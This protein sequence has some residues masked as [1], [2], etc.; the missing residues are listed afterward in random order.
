MTRATENAVEARPP[1]PAARKGEKPRIVIIGAGY[2][3]AYCAQSLEKRLRGLEAEV[4]LIDRHNYFVFYPLLIEAGTGSLEPRHA[5]VPIRAFLK[6]SD[7]RMA[8][9]VDLDIDRQTVSYRLAGTQSTEDKTSKRNSVRPRCKVNS[10]CASAAGA[11]MSP[12]D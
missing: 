1:A 8:E 6:R 10:P 11:P 12:P 9:A 3:G 7:F 5:V 2:G 4:L